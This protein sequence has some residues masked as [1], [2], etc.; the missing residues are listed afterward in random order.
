MTIFEQ[1]GPADI[2]ENYSKSAKTSIFGPHNTGENYS[3]IQEFFLDLGWPLWGGACR[4]CRNLL[5]GM[6]DGRAGT[7]DTVKVRPQDA[8]SGAPK[9][10]AQV[11]EY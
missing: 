4:Q 2:E 7:P 9:N 8:S 10:A 5:L 11:G 3:K 6:G 1:F